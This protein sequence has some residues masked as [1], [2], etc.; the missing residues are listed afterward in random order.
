MADK[1]EEKKTKAKDKPHTGLAESWFRPVRENLTQLAH[2]ILHPAGD[3]PAGAFDAESCAKLV[4]QDAIQTNASDVHLEPVSKGV[5]I[6]VRVDG[7]LH[8]ATLLS[9]EQGDRLIRY[10]KSL[11]QLDPVASFKPQDARTRYELDG[12]RLDLRL[13]C[14]PCQGGEKLVLR[15]LDADRV[16]HRIGDL[17]LTKEDQEHFKDWL[18][19]IS[20]MC[21]VAGPTG[22]GKTT[23]LYAL[24][25]E[26]K[27]HTKSIV[28]IE[29]P[30]EYSI[31]GITQIQVSEE[32]G[33]TFLEGIKAMLRLDPDYLLVGEIRDYASARAAVEASSSG[34]VLLSTLHS[35]DTAGVIT[36]LRNWQVEDFE[37]ATNLELVVAQRL[38]RRLCGNCRGEAAPTAD[39]RRWLETLGRPVLRRVWRARGCGE[40]HDT[41]YRGRTGVFEI[42]RKSNKDHDLILSGAE[43]AAL[44]GHMRKLGRNSLLDD[45]LLKVESGKTSLEEVRAM[46]SQTTLVTSN[47]LPPLKAGRSARSPAGKG[48]RRNSR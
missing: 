45:G 16:E 5:L 21:L 36:S 24:L 14:V 43:E 10:Y 12:H 13:A 26:L 18:K 48:K 6:R 34:R 46:S 4:L 39:E 37:I 47:L 31:D 3:R 9:H 38:V 19:D 30:V 32:H 8:D 33:L 25:Q 35:R 2:S 28:T 42:W 27:V 17:G 29:D 20:G 40:C 44:R 22:S 11:A 1:N 15:V 23:T 7:L 41:G